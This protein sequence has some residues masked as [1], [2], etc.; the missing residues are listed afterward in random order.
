M[1]GGAATAFLPKFV[2]FPSLRGLHSSAVQL[3]RARVPER[4]APVRRATRP[5]AGTHGSPRFRAPPEMVIFPAPVAGPAHRAPPHGTQVVLQAGNVARMHPKPPD[6]SSSD[7]PSGSAGQ[8]DA[9]PAQVRTPRLGGGGFPVV[10]TADVSQLP[11]P[12]QPP[13]PPPQDDPP[14]QD[15]PPPQECP[16]RCPSPP[17]EPESPPPAHQLPLPLSLLRLPLLEP[18]DAHAPRRVV[19]RVPPLRAWETSAPISTTPTTARMMPTIMA[20]P[21]FHSPEAAPRGRL[22]LA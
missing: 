3:R 1:N 7:R 21:S 11:P 19:R 12:P 20:S 14:P 17:E 18:V 16:P 6:S 5:G 8:D 22:A 13:P 9:G 15:E 4:R 10:R 2:G